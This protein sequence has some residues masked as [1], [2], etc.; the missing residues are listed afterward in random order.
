M[1]ASVVSAPE[2]LADTRAERSPVA[3][4]APVQPISPV[5]S[6]DLA[7]L[8]EQWHNIVQQLGLK[9]YARQLPYQS[10]LIELSAERLVLRCEK[11]SLATDEGTLKMLRQSLDD[12][13][14]AR[15]QASPKL[16]VHIAETDQVRFSPQKL[17]LQE[18]EAHQ[19]QA[20]G[21]ITQHPTIQRIVHEFDGMI[22]P[23]SIT[24]E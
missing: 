15:H 21:A 4:A 12:Y 7:V 16:L 1:S 3:A 14:T 10:E 23:N 8:A 9:A 20:R 22:L 6:S 13:F 18:R 5:G 17:T 19:A 11:A 2:P 24:P